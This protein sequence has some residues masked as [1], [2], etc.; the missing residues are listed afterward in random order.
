MGLHFFVAVPSLSIMELPSVT[1]A[2]LLRQKGAEVKRVRTD[3]GGEYMGKEFQHIYGELSITHETT[4]PYMPEHNGIAERY[5]R[6]L[7]EG[8][9]TLCSDSGLSIQFWVSAV[10]TVNFI[11]NQ[12]IHS[13]IG[14]LPH[15]AFWG[16]KPKVDW[17]RTYGSK[18]W[19]LVPKAI[20]R[21]G[22]FRSIEGIFIG[23]FD[24]L[25]AYKI[26]SPQTHTVIKSRDVIF[27][28]YNHIERV[29]IHSMDEEDSP[30]LWTTEIL[31]NITP[32]HTP[33]HSSHPQWIEDRQLPFTPE[34]TLIASQGVDQGIDRMDKSGTIGVQDSESKS[35][36]APQDFERGKWLDP[37]NTSFGRG[38]CHARG[39]CAFT[40]GE[41]ELGHELIYIT[42]ADDELSNFREA[43]SSTNADEWK[44][45]CKLEYD[46][47]MGYGMWTLIERPPDTNI[48]GNRWVF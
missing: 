38:M 21:K 41:Y 35:I 19:A 16:I 47:L 11:K 13:R 45:T 28:E 48:V 29:T 5:N 22:D 31:T 23:Y 36:Y 8:A 15:E 24:D 17:L 44:A 14:I 3:N 6:T 26:W 39:L 32:I 20:R 7:Q 25:K 43:M 2:W 34:D 18:C 10:H 9:L 37:T 4:S 30:N 46:T 40:N 27:D 42:L 33:S 1:V 12:L